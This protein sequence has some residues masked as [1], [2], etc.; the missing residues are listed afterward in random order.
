MWKESFIIGIEFIDQQHKEL[1]DMVEKLLQIIDGGDVETQKHECV[2]AI[3]FL[4][5]YAGRHFAA[6]EEFQLSIDYS[7]IIAHKALHRA[8]SATV[9]KLD[10]KLRESDYSAPAVKEFTGFLTTWLTYHIAGVDQK[11]KKKER[12]SDDKAAM[13]SSYMHSFAESAQAV[14]ETMAELGERSVVTFTTWPGRAEDVRIMIG[15]TGDYNGE[16]V[17]T[18]TRD[19][20]FSLIRS[21]TS[22]ERTEIDELTY[23]ALSEVANIISGNASQRISAGGRHSD[24]K[25]PKIIKEFAGE[26]NRSGFYMDSEI[27][28]LAVSVNLM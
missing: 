21:L 16:A 28:R 22:L 23:S 12:L 8:F 15:L 20:A 11:L 1:C 26:D 25:T 19:I 5:D 24:I 13:I 2:A 27:G 6:E 3:Q 18:F 7:D 10:E 17:F 14:L 4:K 9:G